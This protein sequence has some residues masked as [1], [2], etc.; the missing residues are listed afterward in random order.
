M[1][2]RYKTPSEL[3]RPQAVARL[4][5]HVTALHDARCD[6]EDF[7]LELA[8]SEHWPELSWAEIASAMGVSRQA[9]QQRVARLIAD[10][11]S[12]TRGGV[13][14]LNPDQLELMA[15]ES[16]KQAI[17]GKKAGKV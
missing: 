8:E 10:G 11:A 1:T 9:V 17:R 5:A 3:S 6:L 14:F 12:R 7:L 4:R 16:V 15:T 13:Q 2:S